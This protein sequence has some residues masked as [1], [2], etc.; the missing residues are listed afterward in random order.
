MA[1]KSPPT[2]LE[3]QPAQLPASVGHPSQDQDDT[4]SDPPAAAPIDKNLLESVE[5]ALSDVPEEQRS[6]TAERVVQIVAAEVY[7][8]PLPHPRHIQAYENACPGLADRI[9]AMAEKAQNRQETRLDRAMAYEYADRRLGL[10]FGFCALLVLLISGVVV[11]YLGF[12][13]TGSALLGAAILGTVIGTFVHGRR[14]S[15]DDEDAS[16]ETDRD[17]KPS[18]LRRLLSAISG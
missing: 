4:T 7:R 8:G 14:S 18:L 13:K 12:E 3:E 6:R 5:A 11:L 10:I 15:D 17:K 16:S 9:V 2:G 1:E